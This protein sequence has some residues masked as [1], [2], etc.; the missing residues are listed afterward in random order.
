MPADGL[1]YLAHQRLGQG[2]V[3]RFQLFKA[4][5]AC[6]GHLTV[7]DEVMKVHVEQFHLEA[8]L[9][10]LRGDGHNS[11][12]ALVVECKGSGEYSCHNSLFYHDTI[13][14]STDPFCC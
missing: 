5:G 7:G 9:V 3:E 1:A 8:K 11:V 6:V 4:A 13:E 2:I 10:V 12:V 14:F